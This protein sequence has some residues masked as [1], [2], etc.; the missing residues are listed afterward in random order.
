VP[1]TASE[2]GAA[3][4]RQIRPC[5]NFPAGADNTDRLLVVVQ[6]DL[7]PDG[8]LIRARV[9]DRARMATDTFFRAAAEA[10]LRAVRDPRCSP[11]RLPAAHYRQWK[12]LTIEFDPAELRSG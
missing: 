9:R 10:A 5:W 11:L 8:G 12:R 3:V 1:L 7:R 2:I 6:I 4:I